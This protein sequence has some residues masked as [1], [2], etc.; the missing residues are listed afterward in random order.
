MPRKG[1]VYA[2]ISI[3]VVGGISV[4]A[5]DTV[6]LKLLLAAIMII[7]VVIILKIKTTESL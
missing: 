5:M 6:T 3:V 7:P 2:I 4:F 1:K